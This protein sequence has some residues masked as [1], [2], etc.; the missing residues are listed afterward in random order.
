MASLIVISGKQTGQFLPL[1]QRTSVIGRAESLP[2]Q[3]LDD[4][5]SRKHFRIR[6]DKGTVKYY[7]EDMRSKHGTFINAHRI[8]QETVLAEDDEIQIG[9]TKMLFT[10]KDF[11]SQEN[12]LMHWKK[13]GEKLRPTYNG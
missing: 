13:V 8:T 9:Q 2:L 6:F 4:M 11:E 3:I 10:E 12:A 1:G 7:A 5:V